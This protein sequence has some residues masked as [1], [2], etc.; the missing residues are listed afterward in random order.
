MKTMRYHYTPIAKSKMLKTTNNVRNVEHW[1][2]LF[3]VAVNTKHYSHFV[4]SLAVS[5]KVKYT[6]YTNQTT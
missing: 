4:D 6:I 5:Y 1:E 3:V 2:H